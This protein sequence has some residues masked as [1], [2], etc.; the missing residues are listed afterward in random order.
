[1]APLHVATLA[2]RREHL[3]VS[4]Q[5]MDQERSHGSTLLTEF[6]YV[7]LATPKMTIIFSRLYNYYMPTL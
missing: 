1:M 6:K 2:V 7:E 4:T 5:S 3:G